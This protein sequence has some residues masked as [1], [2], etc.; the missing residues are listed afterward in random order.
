[1]SDLLL[2]TISFK[3]GVGENCF[4][5]AVLAFLAEFGCHETFSHYSI[6]GV[7]VCRLARASMK[8]TGALALL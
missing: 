6:N 8:K 7:F 2:K 5:P 1:M 3:I 4:F